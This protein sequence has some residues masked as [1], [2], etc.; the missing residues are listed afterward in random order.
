MSSNRETEI[1]VSV[2]NLIP[3]LSSKA[4]EELVEKL[5]II[6]CDFDAVEA[7]SSDDLMKIKG[8]GPKYADILIKHKFELT[9]AIVTMDHVS[10]DKK[11]SSPLESRFK[12]MFNQEYDP[13]KEPISKAFYHEEVRLIQSDLDRFVRSINIEPKDAYFV[14]SGYINGSESEQPNIRV[15][16]QLELWKKWTHFGL[17]RN[18]HVY[19]ARFHGT[20][21]GRKDEVLFVRDDIEDRVVDYVSAEASK[22]GLITE[23]K[24]AAYLGLKMPGTTAVKD[25]IGFEVDPSE[26]CIVPEWKKTFA[27]QRVDFV[28]VDN[29]VVDIDVVRNVTENMFDGQA[30]FHVSDKKLQEKLAGMNFAKR[31]EVMRKLRDLPN[32]SWRYVFFK[33]LVLVDVDFHKYF[34]DAGITHIRRKDGELVDIDDIILLGD[35]S[36]LKAKIGENG[37]FASWNDFC[38]KARGNNHTFQILIVEHQDR[39]HNLPFQQMQSTIGA[40]RET[41]EPV[42]RREINKLNAYSDKDKAARLIGGEISKI[43]AALPQMF[44]QPWVAERASSAYDKLLRQ[45]KAGVVHGV[46]HNLFLGKDPIAFL[47]KVEWDNNPAIQRKYPNVADYATGCIPAKSV[48]CRCSKAHKAVMSRNPSTDAQAQCVVN[49]QHDAGKFEEYFRW[50]TVC[51]ASVN[52]YETTRIRG[53]HDGDHISLCDDSDIVKMA[54]EANAFTGGRLIDWEAP[55]TEKHHV[56]QDSM[57]NYFYSLTKTSQLGH[58][59][60]KL[61]SLLGFGSKGYDHRVACWLVMAVNVFVDASKHGMGDVVV[62]EF[63][64]EFLQMHDEAG[65]LLVDNKNRPIDRPMPIYA[66]QAKD[67][68]HP[69]MEQKKVGSKRCA[70]QYGWGNGDILSRRVSAEAMPQL[71]IDLTGVG[72]FDVNDLMMDFAGIR[73][74]GKS[75]GLRGCDELF[76]QGTF[77][78]ETGKYE[79]EGLWKTMVFARAHDLKELQDGMDGDDRY[80]LAAARKNYEQ[81]RRALSLKTL[82][83]WAEAHSRTIE[84]IYDAATFYTWH[85]LRY[86][87]LRKNETVEQLE[88]RKLQY[89]IMV[90]G[91]TKIFGGM[92]LKALYRRHEYLASGQAIQDFNDAIDDLTDELF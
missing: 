26:L 70:K 82:S 72:D 9:K 89:N 28:H 59:C 8:V 71:K 78:Q 49:V 18:G 41:F 81:F 14:F 38:E 77:N 84:D 69:S 73:N 63:V 65:N 46:T 24:F 58:F 12:V 13:A 88:K 34:H 62:P 17:K 33:A 56:T 1:K 80:M 10:A 68:A 79:D 5:V 47:Q 57:N 90:E 86:P 43:V 55:A 51:Y 11:P 42:V 7:L 16:T 29:G 35:E 31:K 3:S 83:D 53:D 40:S 48:L 50:S 20:N 87:T 66:M 45:S 2:K 25:W 15:T 76:N 75:F 36:V 32:A 74:G 39:P 30:L 67:N 92:A 44:K 91:W 19:H 61:T 54:E 52:S 64:E 22:E 23:A 6:D 27:N 21:A 4:V 60:D 85:S 37:Q